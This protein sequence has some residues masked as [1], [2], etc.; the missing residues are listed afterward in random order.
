MCVPVAL[1]VCFIAAATLKFK[2]T[3]VTIYIPVFIADCS[4][5]PSAS[6][7]TLAASRMLLSSAAGEMPFHDRQRIKLIDKS[8]G[9][10]SCMNFRLEV[11][12]PINFTV[13]SGKSCTGIGW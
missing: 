6:S 4:C 2:T 11:E 7:T 13:K 10:M 12:L 8:Q 1:G 9:S 3:L 5:S